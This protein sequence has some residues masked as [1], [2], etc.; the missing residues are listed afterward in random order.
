MGIEVDQGAGVE[1]YIGDPYGYFCVAVA[2]HWNMSFVLIRCNCRS[3]CYAS[4]VKP[5]TE[6]L[7]RT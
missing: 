5:R 4:R 3:D 6:Q 1:I 2:S 7:R